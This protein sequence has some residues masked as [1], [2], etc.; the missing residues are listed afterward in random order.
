MA[1][2]PESIF[3]ELLKKVN[4]ATQRQAKSG[5]QRIVDEYSGNVSRV[6]KNILQDVQAKMMKDQQEF[7]RQ[8]ANTGADLARRY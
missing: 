1:T 7:D 8:Y 4:K 5:L 2:A 3:D 6:P